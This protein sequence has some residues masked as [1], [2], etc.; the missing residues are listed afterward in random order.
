MS[1]A[2]AQEVVV[3]PLWL[4]LDQMYLQHEAVLSDQPLYLTAA[5]LP[6]SLVEFCAK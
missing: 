3:I 6:S 4:Y 5:H 1:G 2:S